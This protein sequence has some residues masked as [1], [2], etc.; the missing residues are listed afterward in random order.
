MKAAFQ[1]YDRRR[2]GLGE[3][4]T[5]EVEIALRRLL[6][7]PTAS[8]IVFHGMGRMALKRFPY[9]VYYLVRGELVLVVAV[10]HSRRNLARLQKR[11][12]GH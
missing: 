6:L 1:W 7:A 12:R 11:V 3:D 8:G 2:K 5:G 10:F 9:G 4:F